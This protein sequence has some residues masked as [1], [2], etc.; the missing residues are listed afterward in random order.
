MNKL[1]LQIS[2]IYNPLLQFFTLRKKFAQKTY[3]LA[4]STDTLIITSI[5]KLKGLN[6]E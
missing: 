3:H 1:K 2:L 4:I 6:F 5:K